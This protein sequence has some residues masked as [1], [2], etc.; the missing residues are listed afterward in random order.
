M[1]KRKV[2]VV[3]GKNPK[4]IT[5]TQDQNPTT[6]LTFFRIQ[7]GNGRNQQVL[8]VVKKCRHLV[9]KIQNKRK[10]KKRENPTA[11]V[12]LNQQNPVR[13]LVKNLAIIAKKSK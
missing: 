5:P 12:A 11:A 9:T 10:R 4:K 8:P 1:N 7:T 13:N 2:N 6:T 3:S